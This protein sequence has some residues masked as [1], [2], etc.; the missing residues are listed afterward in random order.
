MLY[1]FNYERLINAVSDKGLS[2]SETAERLGISENLY[3]LK[4]CNQE[5]FTM[6]E[7]RV[8]AEQILK[9]SPEEIPDY[10]FCQKV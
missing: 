2:S 1:N 4:L 5:E 9:I 7:I 6:G 3:L 10:F 8:F